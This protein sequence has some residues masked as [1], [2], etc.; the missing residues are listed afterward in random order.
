ML[1]KNEKLF[2]SEKNNE[3]VIMN[4]KNGRFF[5]LQDVSYDVWKLLD[6]CIEIDEIVEGI[7]QNY[8]V[9]RDVAKQDISNVIDKMVEYGLVMNE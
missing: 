7:V 5:G 8:D 2:I 4:M 6:N 1:K 9:D 3:I